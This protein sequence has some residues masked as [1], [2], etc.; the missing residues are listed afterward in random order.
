MAAARADPIARAVFYAIIACW[1]IFLVTFALRAR[2]MKSRETK[3]DRTAMAGFCLQA[4]GYF[5][6]WLSPLQRKQFSAIV[7]MPRTAEVVLA[8]LTVALA[9][10]SVWLVNAASRR[11]GKQWALAARLVEGH[12]LISDGP[13]RLVR[14]PIYTGMFGLLLAT[15]LAMSRWTTLLAASAVFAVGTLIRIR[16]E[17]RLLRQAF[18][19][20]F[21]EYARKVPALIP[22]I[23]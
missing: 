2:R 15:G 19:A 12:D 8:V 11:L 14:N 10:A 16:S 4:V 20:A 13:Y 18:G 6:V 3:R 22:G 9:A 21:D 7:P 17:E 23:Y 1:W 5:A